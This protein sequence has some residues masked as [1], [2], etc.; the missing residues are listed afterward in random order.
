MADGD[1]RNANDE[2]RA[3]R[4]SREETVK[5][6]YQRAVDDLRKYLEEQRPIRIDPISLEKD[7][8]FKVVDKGSY[9][10]V[11]IVD[12]DFFGDDREVRGVVMS[13]PSP[14]EEYEIGSWYK[15]KEGFTHL[16]RG[17]GKWDREPY[18]A[19]YTIDMRR[20]VKP[21]IKSIGKIENIREDEHGITADFIPDSDSEKLHEDSWDEAYREWKEL[22]DRIER[23]RGN[24][25]SGMER[26]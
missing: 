2:F 4:L 5:A 21:P 24:P 10:E 20:E 7:P 15:D 22:G 17:N 3:R 12:P 26:P 25:D 1:L 13:D 6:I 19:Y 8:R 18:R 23:I 11:S 16:Y 9:V 14:M